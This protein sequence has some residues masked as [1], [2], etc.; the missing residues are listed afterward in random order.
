MARKDFLVKRSRRVTFD[1]KKEHMRLAG[2]YMLMVLTWTLFGL[3]L[4]QYLLSTQ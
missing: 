4:A 1:V 3:A 2:E